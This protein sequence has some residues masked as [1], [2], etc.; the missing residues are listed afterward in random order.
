MTFTVQEL[1][2]LHV[3]GAQVA[4]VPQHAGAQEDRMEVA[5]PSPCLWRLCC[6]EGPLHAGLGFSA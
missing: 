5:L 4:A 1:G 2:R 6:C 3:R